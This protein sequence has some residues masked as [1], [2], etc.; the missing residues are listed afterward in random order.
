MLLGVTWRR[1]VTAAFRSAC[2]PACARPSVRGGEIRFSAADV[3]PRDG[4]GTAL[5]G[6]V[7]CSAV[8]RGS[9][10]AATELLQI[11]HTAVFGLLL[12]VFG[13]QTFVFT[14][15]VEMMRRLAK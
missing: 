6:L 14:L 1:W 9:T 13:F 11:S 15:L 2:L 4:T 3:R 5:T 12:I 8:S 10:S 7:W